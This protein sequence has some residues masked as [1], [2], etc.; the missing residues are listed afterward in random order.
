MFP[1]NCTVTVAGYLECGGHVGKVRDAASDD[2]D[3]AWVWSEKSKRVRKVDLSIL[4]E[5]QLSV[6]SSKRGSPNCS[7]G[8][9]AEVGGTG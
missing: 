7:G 5:S 3:L 4:P 6:L 1:G 9:R 2:E 8:I